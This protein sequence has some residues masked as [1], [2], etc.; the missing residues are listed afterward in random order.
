MFKLLCFNCQNETLQFCITNMFVWLFAC[1]K[2]LHVI[3]FHFSTQVVFWFN[4]E[5]DQVL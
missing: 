5:R 1:V 4:A 3:I 2:H